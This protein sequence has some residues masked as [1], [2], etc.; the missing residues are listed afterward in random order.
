MFHRS[1]ATP[2]MLSALLAVSVALGLP[3]CSEQS[4]E[5]ASAGTSDSATTARLASAQEKRREF[6]DS[7]YFPDRTTNDR[8]ADYVAMEGKP[9]PQ[10]KLRDWI[11][12]I[13][14][15][16]QLQGRII[17]V[18]FWATW[19]P[20]CVAAIPK[21]ITLTE[22]YADKGM[23]ILGIH[24]SNRGWDR[25]PAM[26]AERK[27]NYPVAIDVEGTSTRAWKVKF[28]P[29]YAVVDHTGIVRAVGL[30]PD[31]VEDVVKVLID[32][33]AKSDA[34]KAAPAG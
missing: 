13:S 26:A 24:D 18:D 30:V 11:G 8:H 32:E 21:N 3:G 7:W 31:R 27:I 9:M 14:S 6:P 33:K 22:K 29:T 5:S 25:M 2:T 20:P 4:D 19:C 10:I 28:W 15:T 1:L 23:I 17:V 12:S 34:A 16:D